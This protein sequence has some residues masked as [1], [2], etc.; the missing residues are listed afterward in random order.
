MN[1]LHRRRDRG[2]D[3]LKRTKGERL[4]WRRFRVR[5]R[6]RVTGANRH[7][8]RHA[9]P[10]C[11][12]GA[13]AADETDRTALPPHMFMGMRALCL[14]STHVG[15]VIARRC[16]TPTLQNA[17][18]FSARKACHWGSPLV[19]QVLCGSIVSIRARHDYHFVYRHI[20]LFVRT[21]HDLK[22]ASSLCWVRLLD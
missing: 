15:A 16:K 5:P 20:W 11:I 12:G 13:C 18:G 14:V 22:L 10:S 21:T 6:R 7:K 8:R 1:E 19:S 3:A 2:F 17:S 9:P 4:R